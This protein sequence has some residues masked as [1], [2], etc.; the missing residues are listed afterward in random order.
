M[1]GGAVNPQCA[2]CEA[3]I[4]LQLSSHQSIAVAVSHEGPRASSTVALT[5][6]LLYPIDVSHFRTLEKINVLP[7]GSL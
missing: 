5:A 4:S 7:F 3:G 2:M 1:A 6:S